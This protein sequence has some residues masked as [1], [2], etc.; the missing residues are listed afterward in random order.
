MSNIIQI[1]VES[2]LKAKA[3]KKAD[4]KIRLYQMITRDEEFAGKRKTYKQYADELGVSEKTIKRYM[5]EMKEA[6]EDEGQ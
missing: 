5:A 1:D 4:M 3:G 2:I 6:Y